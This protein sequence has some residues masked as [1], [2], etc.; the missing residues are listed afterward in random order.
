MPY[1]RNFTDYRPGPRDDGRPWTQARIEEAADVAGAPGTW[2][3]IDTI[4]FSPVDT[5]PA[6]PRLRDITTEDAALAAGW[7]RVVFVDADGDEQTTDPVA[8]PPST[9]LRPTLLEVGAILRARTRSDDTG[10][11]IG[12]FDT[13]TRPTGDEVTTYITEAHDEVTLR[14]PDDLPARYI[15][16][17]RRL[18]AMRA[19]MFIE[20]SFDPDRTGPDSAYGRLKEQ[21]DAGMAALM[22]AVADRGDAVTS[23]IASPDI[24]SPTLA[25]YPQE[26]RELI[27]PPWP[28]P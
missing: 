28:Y 4:T 18:I 2:A 11:E 27:A 19:A 24:I 3:T 23:R 1:V 13:T 22:D 26:L 8:Y 10:Q 16:F 5:D 15:P 14:L 17:A 25:P 12:T 9:T 6:A 21:F 7:Y 20:V